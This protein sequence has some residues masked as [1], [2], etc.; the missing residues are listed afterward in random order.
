MALTLASMNVIELMD[1][2]RGTRVLS[3]VSN[4]DMD[5]AEVQ[6]T[7]FICERGCQVLKR[8]C[9]VLSAFDNHYGAGVSLLVEQGLEADISLVFA[10]DCVRL[11]VVDVAMKS[12][13]F[14]VVA[15]YVP[16]CVE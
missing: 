12:F 2:S 5:E 15:I 3:E 9:V 13:L 8:N 1:R 7:H 11:V 14:R 4:L 10:G 16:N 6:E